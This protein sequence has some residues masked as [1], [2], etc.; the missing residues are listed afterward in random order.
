MNMEK[1]IERICDNCGKLFYVIPSRI[2]HG[3]GK[4]CSPKCQYES[5]KLAPRTNQVKCTCLGCGRDFFLPKSRMID[6]IG[7]GKYCS[8]FCRDK[9]RVGENHPQYLNGASQEKRGANWQAQ[10]RRA[11]KRDQGICQMCG[12][13]GK[14]VHHKIPFRKFGIERYKQ[15]NELSNL[16]TLCKHCHR[17]ADIEIQKID[18]SMY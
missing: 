8:R 5:K 18:R 2:K 1:T 11:I 6:R 14:D 12:D 15:A 10:K 9:Y 17:K 16:I 7:A 4:H 3:R 13:V